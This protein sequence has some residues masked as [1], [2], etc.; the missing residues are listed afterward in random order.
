M[1]DSILIRRL[2]RHD[3]FREAEEVQR[4]AW[5]MHGDTAMV[6]AH[7]LITI[8]HNGG[9]VLG[10]YTPDGTM[11]GFLFGFLASTTDERAA[12][13]GTP[14]YHCSHMMGIRPEYQH[15]SIGSALKLAQRRYVLEQG[16]SL[17]VWTYDP[18]M[19]VNARLNIGRLRAVCTRYLENLYDE[20]EEELNAGMPTDRFEV[21]WWITSNHVADRIKEPVSLSSAQGWRLMGAVPINETAVWRDSLRAPASWAKRKDIPYLMV[22]FPSDFQNIRRADIGLAVEWRMHT[23]EIFQWAFSND[24]VAAWFAMEEG[25]G[26][27]R[28]YYILTH[29]ENEALSGLGQEAKQDAD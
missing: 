5:G 10:A 2:E 20:I 17:I 14:Y 21:D 16:L 28:S 12:R 19:S 6:P 25:K 15:R 23:R 3:E 8:E 9:L 27:R 7:L 1:A 18:L 29:Q 4:L 22:E 13:I 26:A 11:A 24:Y